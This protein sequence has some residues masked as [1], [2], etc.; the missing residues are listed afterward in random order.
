MKKY[1]GG[2]IKSPEWLK[3][4]ADILFRAG[5]RCEGTP[6][7]P[8]CRAHNSRPHPETGSIVVLTIMHMNHDE[9]DNDYENLRAGC[10]RCHNTYDMPHRKANAARTRRSKSPQIDMWD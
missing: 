3:I 4:R 7:Y 6:Q 8:D 10:Q 2:S 5:N 9:G 1:P